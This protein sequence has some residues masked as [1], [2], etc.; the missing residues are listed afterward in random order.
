MLIYLETVL[1]SAKFI[2][3]EA[4]IVLTFIDVGVI[5]VWTLVVNWIFRKLFPPRDIL[6]LYEEYDPTS[7]LR[8]VNSRKDRY[9]IK[10]SMNVEEGWDRITEEM[11]KFDAVFSVIYILLCVIISKV[12]LCRRIR[13]YITPKI[14]DI[15]IRSS[16]NIPFF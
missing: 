1:L 13:S 9:N 16:E 5:L 14:S 2:P 12:L 10:E 4:M 3:V 8:K 6:L 11:K 7:F 15:I